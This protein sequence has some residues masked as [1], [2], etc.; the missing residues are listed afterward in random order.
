[1]ETRHAQYG[2]TLIELVIVIILIGILS[3]SVYLS[4]PKSSVSLDAQA[5]Q[6]AHDIRYAQTLAMTKGQRYRFV[7]TSSTSYQ[8]TNNSGTAVMLALGSAIVTL[9]AGITFSGF[10]NLPNNLIAF[11]GKGT[12]YT[13]TSSPGTALASTATISLTANGETRTISISP[14]TGRVIVS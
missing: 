11:D 8:V 2:F 3:T 1:M 7:R 10:T 13:N 14:G 12:P 9:N 6:I 4:W 5:H